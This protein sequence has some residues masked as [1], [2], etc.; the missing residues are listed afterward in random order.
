VAERQAVNL[1]VV[2]SN[3]T[4]S[5]FFILLVLLNLKYNKK[6]LNIKYFN[7]RTLIVRPFFFKELGLMHASARQINYY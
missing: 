7:I 1:E 6:K 2:G 4:K 3:L 5:V